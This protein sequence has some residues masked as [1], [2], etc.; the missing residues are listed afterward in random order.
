[1]RQMAR[2]ADLG[3]LSRA[4]TNEELEAALTD[5]VTEGLECPLEERRQRMESHIT[6]NYRQLRSQL[7]G[8]NG[9][10][11]SFGCT[12]IVVLRCWRGS[13]DNIL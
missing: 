7:P 12:D 9:K 3:N 8:C 11:T 6:S 4:A 1:M 2:V 13:K 10:C 5:D